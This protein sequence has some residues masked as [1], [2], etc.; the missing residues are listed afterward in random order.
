[1]KALGEYERREIKWLWSGRIPSGA[2]TLLEGDGG[3]GKSYIVSDLVARLSAGNALP[4]DT[5]RAS[6]AAVCVFAAEDDPGSIMLDRYLAAG[7]DLSRVYVESET[8][9]LSKRGIEYLERIVGEH[10]PRLIVFDP[11]IAYLAA[12]TDMNKANDVRALLAPLAEF[13]AKK[14]IAIVIVRH[15][16]KAEK[17]SASYRGA[18]SADF[19]NASRSV[20]QVIRT[21]DGCFVTVEKSNYGATGKTL[22]FSIDDGVFCWTGESDMSANDILNLHTAAGREVHRVRAAAEALIREMANADGRIRSKELYDEGKRRNMSEITIRR[23]AK[24]LGT[25]SEKVGDAWWVIVP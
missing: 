3:V 10:Q 9:D 7:A 15:W 23:A 14:D 11:I 21:G 13:A 20:L 25:R 4:C 5:A 18:G 12:G 16:N 8:F 17:S 1:M 19:R 2:I 6:A 22:T 24:A